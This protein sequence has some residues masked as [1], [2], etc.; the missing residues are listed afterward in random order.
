MSLYTEW[1]NV[2]KERATSAWLTAG[3]RA[4]YEQLTTR[5]QGHEFVALCG[6]PG[7]GKTFIAR[8]LATE[9]GYHYAQEWVAVPH[10]TAKV[11]L[12]GPEYTRAARLEAISREV[13]RVVIAQERLPR[14]PA[15]AVV[16]IALTEQDAR[17]FRATL[18]SQHVIAW[19]KSELVGTDLGGI[20]RAEAIERGR[21]DDT[22]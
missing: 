9:H 15:M 12:D 10:G 3:Q 14:E 8:L 21:S 7:C 11:V 5:W 17:Q 6:P 16:T 20:L 18:A 4:A 1:L 19:W 13:R 22:E 2:I